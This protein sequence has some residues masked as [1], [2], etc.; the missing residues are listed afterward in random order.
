MVME[1]NN[2]QP[3]TILPA[4]TDVVFQ[5]PMTARVESGKIMR[6]DGNKN[7]YEIDLEN[8]MMCFVEFKRFI[9]YTI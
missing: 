3:Q 8:G 9:A 7:L 5:R 2:H 6:F 4:G 1:N